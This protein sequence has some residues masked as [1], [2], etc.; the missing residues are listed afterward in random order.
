[1]ER[2]VASVK[3][4]LFF[5]F[6]SKARTLQR[7]SENRLALSTPVALWKGQRGRG[8]AVVPA[9]ALSSSRLLSALLLCL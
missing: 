6:W 2:N 9:V 3:K 1:M 7:F 8:E 5:S 4:K